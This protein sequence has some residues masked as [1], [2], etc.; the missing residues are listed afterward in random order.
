MFG[1]YVHIV[2]IACLLLLLWC[3][4][5]LRLYPP[6][7]FFYAPGSREIGDHSYF[8]ARQETEAFSLPSFLP[9]F[10]PLFLPSFLP[11]FLPLRSFLLRSIL[12][13]PTVTSRVVDVD[14]FT[15]NSIRSAV[16]QQ[17]QQSAVGSQQ[18]STVSG[19]PNVLAGQ[20]GQWDMAPKNRGRQQAL[21]ASSGST[22]S[23][24][25]TTTATISTTSSSSAPG[26]G[27]QMMLS[28]ATG[29]VAGGGGGDG[30]ATAAAAA[31]TSGGKPRT[32]GSSE[33]RYEY[34]YHMMI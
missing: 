29:E 30:N 9:S 16:Q 11:S 24:T 18:R 32:R 19:L 3:C 25:A 34:V 17:R 5:L 10:F 26:M 23:T 27:D 22:T 15:I 4:L 1:L 33:V 7:P 6:R 21:V 14:L 2:L 12:W 20:W 28:A 13:D 8:T 31:T